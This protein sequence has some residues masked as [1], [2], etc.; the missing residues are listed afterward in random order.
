MKAVLLDHVRLPAILALLQSDSLV[1][2]ENMARMS[3]TA[4]TCQGPMSWSKES[5][6]W[7]ILSIVNTDPTCQELMFWLKAFAQ[8]FSFSWFATGAVPNM[9]CM[10][11]TDSVC[12][13]FMGWLNVRA[14]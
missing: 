9:C 14:L 5:A 4:S 2:A 10:L 13:E 1:V 6:Y 7:N 12:H 3:V 11:V 8:H